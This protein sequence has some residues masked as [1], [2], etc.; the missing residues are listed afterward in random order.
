MIRIV[1]RRSRDVT[2]LTN[3]PAWEIADA[4]G[5]T[6][7]W[8]LRGAGDPHQAVDVAEV[9]TSTSR[10]VTVGYDLI[11]AAPRPISI[12][13]ALDDESAR[14]IVRAH[15]ESVAVALDYLERYALRVTQQ[16]A[17]E[18]WRVSGTWAAA[19]GFTHGVNRHGDPHLHDHVLVGARLRGVYGV[20]DSRFL[21]M[22]ARAADALYRTHLRDVI[23][24]TT[25]YRVWRSFYG[26]EHLRGLDEGYRLRWGGHHLE[27]GVKLAWTQDEAR[28]NWRYAAQQVE[29]LVVLSPPPV[30]HD[31]NEHTFASQLA[32]HERVGRH[33]LVAAWANAA[34]WGTSARSVLSNIDVHYPECIPVDGREE[35][36]ISRSRAQAVSYV[37]AHGPRHLAIAAPAP[38]RSGAFEIAG[39][40]RP[41]LVQS[42]E[43]LLWA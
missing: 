21:R 40:C 3:D 23:A 33:D 17:G 42:N 24:H 12:V 19:V 4:R 14:S 31:L 16:E 36:F 20:L 7:G 5:A 38:Q 29:P 11:I 2:Y 35:T 1:T 22:H 15:R 43:P 27:R 13:M 37:K 25:P 41:G 32:A 8:F 26:G 6:A 39:Q 10:S 18:R 30:R 9:L 34:T 28:E